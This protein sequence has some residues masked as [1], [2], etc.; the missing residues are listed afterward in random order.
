M[1]KCTSDNSKTHPVAGL[2]PHSDK[3]RNKENPRQKKK[4]KSQPKKP[5][6]PKT[7]KNP[8]PEPYLCWPLGHC[9]TQ[10]PKQD[11]QQ[12]C[13]ETN[14]AMMKAPNPS[15]LH[16]QANQKL[17]SP[18]CDDKSPT[19]SLGMTLVPPADPGSKPFPTPERFSSLASQYPSRQR[20]DPLLH[21][22]P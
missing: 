11:H 2:C 3:H 17:K 22:S 19:T 1:T 20:R 6:N 21:S 8:S 10:L 4:K 9:F 12:D 15:K 14:H 18:I 5:T 16:S 7:N 13:R